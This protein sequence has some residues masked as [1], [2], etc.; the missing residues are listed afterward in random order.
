MDLGIRAAPAVWSDPNGAWASAGAVVVQSTWDS[1]I[2]PTRFLAWAK[3]VEQERLLL[4][5]VR[6]LE[7]NLHKSYLRDLSG[8]GVPVTETEWRQR[9]EPLDIARLLQ[10]RGWDRA[11]VKPAMSASAYETHVV[12]IEDID[13][14]QPLIDHLLGDHDVLV[15]PYLRAFETEGERSYIF[16]DGRL[17]HAVR[18]PPTLATATRS[19]D[20]PVRFDPQPSEAG[21]AQAVVDALDEMPLYARVDL[22]ANNDGVVRL[23][24][25][26]LIE[27]CLFT[28]LADGSAEQFAC[29]IARRL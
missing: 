18:R 2:D 5:P 24:E 16:F 21:L 26:E 9:G 29:A 23:Q 6:L 14:A 3:A 4:N 22:A 12:S 25:L 13:L 11:V 8:R 19:F 1:H 15:Q 27:P 7:W 20:D 28:L 17:S 10:A